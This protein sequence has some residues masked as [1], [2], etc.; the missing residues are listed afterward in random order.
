MGRI[1]VMSSPAATPPEIFGRAVGEWTGAV[2]TVAP[3]PAA[4]SAAGRPEF[5]SMPLLKDAGCG[6]ASPM[7]ASLPCWSAISEMVRGAAGRAIDDG[8]EDVAAAGWTWITGFGGTGASK[9]GGSMRLD[10]RSG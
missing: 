1:G 8:A 10:R 5:S 3:G 6:G 4:V 7:A 2:E 9:R